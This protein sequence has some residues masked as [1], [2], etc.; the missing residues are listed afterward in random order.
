[1]HRNNTIW[2]KTI[3]GWSEAEKAV[4]MQNR[5]LD[6]LIVVDN[7]VVAGDGEIAGT[8]FDRGSIWL[9]GYNAHPVEAL[10]AAIN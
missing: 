8:C 1:M 6:R 5:H 2:P 7:L 4:A 3:Q 9:L 10:G